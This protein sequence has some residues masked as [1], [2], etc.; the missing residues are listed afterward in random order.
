[1]SYPIDSKTILLDDGLENTVAPSDA[2]VT[3]AE[4]TPTTYAN[5]L[6]DE[7]FGDV[8][9]ILDNT[10][11]PPAETIR[12]AE[13]PR[14][15]NLNLDLAAFVTSRYPQLAPPPELAS[16]DAE[17]P[18]LPAPS[19]ELTRHQNRQNS[20]NVL[21]RLLLFV[22]ATSATA[23]LVIWLGSQGILSRAA[24]VIQRMSQP[25]VATAPPVDPVEAQ[26]AAYLERSLDAIQRQPLAGTPSP[27]AGSSVT[28]IASAP[29]PG[30]RTS[31][32]LPP[33]QVPGSPVTSSLPLPQPNLP[34]STAPVPQNGTATGSNPGTNPV[35]PVNQR[36][37]ADQIL[38]RLRNLLNNASANRPAAIA[39]A[40]NTGVRPVPNLVR[41]TN[42]AAAVPVVPAP[43]RTLRAVLEM[44]NSSAVLFEMNGVTQRYE[45]GETIGSSGWTLVEVAKDTV[46]IRR[47]GEVRTLSVGQKL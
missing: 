46:V 15:S 47:N 26:F 16:I 37:E 4:P 9:R 34:N 35:S 45:P 43:Q 20:Y 44:G 14:S 38:D 13:P 8:D 33:V 6:M 11:I 29:Q 23:A 31:T 24:T 19:T 21:E 7:L 3:A 39:Q 10:M 27:A 41:P 5:S 1:M 18:E 17:I 22:G 25:P 36:S 32:T 12:V 2:S 42:S 28:T 30:A 40:P